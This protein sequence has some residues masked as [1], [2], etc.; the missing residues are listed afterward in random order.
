MLTPKEYAGEM[1]TLLSEVGSHGRRFERLLHP[2]RSLDLDTLLRL[3]ELMLGS[4]KRQPFEGTAA[5]DRWTSAIRNAETS[6]WSLVADV[7]ERMMRRLSEAVQQATPQQL[8]ELGV[9][10]VS[11][12]SRQPVQI[13]FASIV[14]NSRFVAE[15]SKSPRRLW[16]EPVDG[17]PADHVL[18]RLIQPDWFYLCGR[19]DTPSV[20]LGAGEHLMSWYWIEDAVAATRSWREPQIKEQQDLRHREQRERE[21]REETWQA[22]P[23]GRAAAQKAKIQELERRVAELEGQQSSK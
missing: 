3:R 7:Y 9:L 18:R 20:V 2:P 19:D 23:E 6:V 17:I 5:R 22:S 13:E 11:D 15:D 12:F 16:T 8:E 21:H 1:T 4:P 10:R 14:P